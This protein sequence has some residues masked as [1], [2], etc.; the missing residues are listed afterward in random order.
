MGQGH[1]THF[2][3]NIRKQLHISAGHKASF[4]R[5]PSSQA[6]K[7]QSFGERISPIKGRELVSL[8]GL[9]VVLSFSPSNQR[10]KTNPFSETSRVFSLRRW[11]VSKMSGLLRY[12]TLSVSAKVE[13]IFFVFIHS[14][15]TPIPQ[16]ASITGTYRSQVASQTEGR[17]SYQ[18]Q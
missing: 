17:G 15:T 18:F 14:S 1:S 3:Y 7:K 5:C 8:T 16:E 6:K 12:K 11:T 13:T 9:T 4:G 2:I 10:Q